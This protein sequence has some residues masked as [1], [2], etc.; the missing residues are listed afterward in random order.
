MYDLA[1]V[2]N[3]NSTLD[4]KL[5][6]INLHCDPHNALTEVLKCVETSAASNIGVFKNDGRLT[7]NPLDPL[8][9]KLSGQQKALQLRRN[10]TI[11]CAKSVKV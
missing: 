8:V 4:E 2:V 11:Y 6:E 10:A 7:D 9:V 1:K 3:S 5:A